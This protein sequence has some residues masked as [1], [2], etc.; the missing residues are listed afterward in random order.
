MPYFLLK[1]TINQNLS[2]YQTG[3][4]IKPLFHIGLLQICYCA[5]I[6]I[7]QY[8]QTKTTKNFKFGIDKLVCQC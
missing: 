8:F 3:L 6:K 2:N 1:F 4:I 7:L 5:V